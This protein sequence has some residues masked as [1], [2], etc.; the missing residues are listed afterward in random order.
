MPTEN[1]IPFPPV[2]RATPEHPDRCVM[3]PRIAVAEKAISDVEASVKAM[4]DK[5][6]KLTMWLLGATFSAAL[7]TLGWV[8]VLLRK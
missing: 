5:L 3:L 8:I 6:D 2:C 4:S 1:V 7:A